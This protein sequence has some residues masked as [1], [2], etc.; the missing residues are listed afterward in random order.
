MKEVKKLKFKPIKIENLDR[1]GI[2]FN[3]EMVK[4]I[5][6]RIKQAKESGKGLN[7]LI[8]GDVKK[9]YG[10]IISKQGEEY[11]YTLYADGEVQ[12]FDWD[13]EKAYT[14]KHLF[15]LEGFKRK[16]N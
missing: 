5:E 12:I 16:N 7:I 6:D 9:G 3:P 15:W 14:S 10:E 2:K 8:G 13:P 1:I 11:S 4:L